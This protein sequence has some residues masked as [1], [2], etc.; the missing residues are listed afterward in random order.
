MSDRRRTIFRR[1]PQD[2]PG[3]AWAE[4]LLAPLRRT[5]VDLDVA[6][7]VMARVTAARSAR[8]LPVPLARPRLAWASCV[9]AGL[10]AFVWL[11]LTL[12]DLARSGEG[13]GQA[14]ALAGSLGHL[15]SLAWGLLVRIGSGIDT[16]A[17]PLLRA[18]GAI[19]SVAAP[20]LRGAGLAAAAAGALSIL[21][22]M[23]VFAN[24][25]AT[26]PHTAGPGGVFP[27]GGTR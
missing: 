25:R 18:L 24:A 15:A 6:P 9:V 2:D 4:E 8:P 21:I 16:A 7:A 5:R 27:H 1:L 17:A 12:L 20:I 3:E 11:G 23:Y 14:R 26:A 13:V 22:S 10:A 19:L